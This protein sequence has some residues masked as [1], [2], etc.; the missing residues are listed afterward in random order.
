MNI[1]RSMKQEHS[2]KPDEQYGIIEA[3][4]P[5]PYLELFGRGKRDGWV[6]WGNQV[7]DYTISWDTYKNNSGKGKR[8]INQLPLGVAEKTTHRD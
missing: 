4:S 6:T 3:C 2:R 5:E 8:N 1:I 7:E